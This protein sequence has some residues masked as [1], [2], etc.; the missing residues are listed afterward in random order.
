MTSNEAVC[1]QLGPAADFVFF[2]TDR[3]N[4]AVAK[5]ICAGCPL[6]EICKDEAARA[7]R[8][9]PE[10]ERFGVFGGTTPAQRYAADPGRVCEDC[11]TNISDLHELARRC[12]EDQARHR[13]EGKL[14]NARHHRRVAA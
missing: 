13:H 14:A 9:K 7:E 2:S 5:A 11:G 8:G 1:A 10:A 4:Q 12:P 6:L 3:V